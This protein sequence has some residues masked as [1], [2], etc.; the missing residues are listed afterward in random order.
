MYLSP[1]PVLIAEQPQPVPPLMI[2][3][4][5]TFNCTASSIPRPSITWFRLR[6]GIETEL[7][8]ILNQ[9]LMTQEDLGDISVRSTLQLI[10]VSEMDFASYFC[11]GQHEFDSTDS[12]I[13]PVV[14]IGETHI[15]THSLTHT[16]THTHTCTHTH[17]L[18]HTIHMYTH[19]LISPHST[20]LHPE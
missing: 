18:T 10:L 7:V 8:N 2:G 12:G 15:H 5:A 13:I 6:N 9:V 11:R 1:A 20:S 14:R 16:H 3:N 19:T 4:I 17:T